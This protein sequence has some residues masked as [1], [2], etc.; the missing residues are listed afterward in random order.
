M[1]MARPRKHVPKVNI[2]ILVPEPAT[3]QPPGHGIS[4]KTTI[5]IGDKT[6]DCDAS[7]LQPRRYL[8]RGAYGVVEEVE[9]MPSNTIMAVKRIM[10]TVN[11][12][13]QK[14]L[15]MDLDIN[16]RSGSCPYTVEFYGALFREGDVM[17]C[18][19]VMEASLDQLNKKL[20]AKGETIPED[21]LAYMALSVVKALHYL[22]TE[23]KVIHRDVKPS[24]ILINQKGQ[25]KICDF[26][27]SGYL[28]D[29]I[30]R[31]KEAGCRPYMAPER[32]NPEAGNQ[33]YDI[34]SDVWS[35]GITMIELATNEFPY[36][37]W[38]TPFEQIKQVVMEDPPRLPPGRFTPEFEDF[39]VQCLLKDFKLR[40]N[41]VQLLEHPFIKR[42]ETTEVDMTGYITGV[43]ERLGPLNEGIQ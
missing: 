42:A 4:D 15:L 21:V 43:I 20:K 28:V 24:N 8:G 13:E 40:P 16:M 25:V 10:A 35:L 30:A 7:D 11:N 9:H 29:S 22:H 6:F 41:Y 27:I 37:R 18:M 38:Q 2:N 5:T 3:P 33:G 1:P 14:R 17:I 23:L 12:L 39:V 32:I 26:G 34:K 36:S 31:T 19:E